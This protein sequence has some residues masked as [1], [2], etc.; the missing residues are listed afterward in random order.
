[1]PQNGSECS[2]HKRYKTKSEDVYSRVGVVELK[3]R[4]GVEEN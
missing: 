1:M 4:I 3:R 2:Y